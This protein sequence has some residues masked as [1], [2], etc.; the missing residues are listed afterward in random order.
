MTL[1]TFERFS[2]LLSKE[3]LRRNPALKNR[4]RHAIINNDENALVR[5][6]KENGY[7]FTIK[8]IWAYRQKHIVDAKLTDRDLVDVARKLG[9]YSNEVAVQASS[10]AVYGTV[11]G[12]PTA[13]VVAS[14]R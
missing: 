11:I 5:L 7:E 4:L 13:I 8:D 14:N 2:H 9:P 10:V 12:D 3:N 1:K 6:G